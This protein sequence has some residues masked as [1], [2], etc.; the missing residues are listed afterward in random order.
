MGQSQQDKPK[1]LTNLLLECTRFPSKK[2][3]G[4]VSPLGKI[5]VQMNSC[6]LSGNQNH[7]HHYYANQPRPLVRNSLTMMDRL[8]ELENLNLRV[9]INILYG[10]QLQPREVLPLPGLTEFREQVKWTLCFALFI[11][12]RRLLCLTLDCFFHGHHPQKQ[13]QDRETGRCY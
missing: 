8:F 12:L 11:A 5:G 13:P 4:Q 1:S 6:I 10:M 7:P 9:A 2:S 3:K